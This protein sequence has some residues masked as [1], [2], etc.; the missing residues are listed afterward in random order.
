MP[1]QASDRQLLFAVLTVQL[2]L[3]PAEVVM[4]A[5]AAC[6]T[7]ASRGLGDRLVDQGA[8][9][10]QQR[11]LIAGM[12][13]EASR[14]NPAGATGA[15][16]AMSL[17]GDHGVART[18]AASLELSHDV[19]MPAADSMATEETTAPSPDSAR[20]THEQPERYRIG[21]EFGRGGQARVLLAMDRHLGREVAW[22]ELLPPAGHA[23]NHS[24]TATALTR[25]LREARITGLLEHPNIVPVHELGRRADGTLYYTMRVVRGQSL[26]QRLAT[27]PDLDARLELL[28]AFWDMCN[29]V[30]FAHSKGVIHRDLKPSNVMVGAF[31]ET[32]VLDWGLAKLQGV[33][34]TRGPEIATQVELLQGVR[35]SKTLAGWAVGTPSYMSPEQADGLIDHIDERSDVWGL[36]AVLY[37]LLTGHPP[38]EGNNPYHVVAQVRT[39]AVAPVASHCAHAP[40]ELVAVAERAL[41]RDPAQRY[42]S[43]RELAEDISAYMTG[44]RVQA[45]EY[46]SWEL[47]R[48]FAAR[49]KAAVAASTIV[50]AAVLVSLVGVAAAWRSAEDARAEEHTQRLQAH[51]VLAQAYGLEADRLLLD[52]QRLK[53]RIFAAASQLNNPANPAGPHHD[54]GFGL[55]RPDAD[56]LLVR[57]SSRLAQASH[58]QV[59]RLEARVPRRDALMD[60]TFSPDGRLVATAEFAQGFTVRE[61]TS[62]TDVMRVPERGTVTYALRFFPDGRRIA[63]GGKGPALQLWELGGN[64]PLLTIEHPELRSTTAVAVS[65]DGRMVASRGGQ[66]I[67]KIAVWDTETGELLALHHPGLQDVTGLAFSPDGRL[68]SCSY[69]DPV[70]IFDPIRGDGLVEIPV[71]DPAMVY[72]VDFSPDGERLLG[73]CTDGRTRI[74]DSHSGEEVEVLQ[75]DDDY[76]YHAA[77]SPD[78]A[79]VATAGAR[80]SVMLWDANTGRQ[81]TKLSDHSGG[82]SAVAF[83]PDG[84]H[85][86]SAGYDRALRLWALAPDDGLPR[87]H[88]PAVGYLV[89]H[90]RTGDRLL[91]SS[92]QD[93][94]QLWDTAS[95][96]QLWD[97]EYGFEYLRA[98]ALSPDGHRV[99]GAGSP[100]GVEIRDTRDGRLLQRLEGHDGSVWGLAWSP[101]SSTLASS[102]SDQTVRLWDLSAGREL[103]VLEE[104]DVHVTS[105]AF[106]R[107]GALLAAAGGTPEI[108]VWR[109]EDRA[110][111]HTLEGHDDWVHALGWVGDSHQLVSGS[112]DHQAILWDADAGQMLRRFT[113]HAQA[114]EM[115]DVHGPSRQL[116]TVDRDGTVLVWHLDLAE[117]SLWLL[118]RT[119][120]RDLAFAPD[121]RSLT[122]LEGRDAVSFP[123]AS[124]GGA[125]GPAAALAQAEADALLRLDGFELAAPE[126]D[127][128]VQAQPAP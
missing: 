86:A 17:D 77:F 126:P 26:D 42:Q 14:A 25:F 68:A 16:A 78:G 11:D 35:A 112:R 99:A 13:A 10:P 20:V 5:A 57:A 118:R 114:I 56:R 85:L 36:G 7:D 123:L 9:T 74:W 82:V 23:A 63:V 117:P 49:N 55:L 127:S 64:E 34:D 98:A 38:F 107:D 125:G 101:D 8:L 80:G 21:A 31:G 89:E 71:P 91:T 111:L 44:R 45:Y 92:L 70:R 113:G 43:A 93:G 109:V 27:C 58:R 75:S 81:L 50:V 48:R 106:S 66:D 76:F 18:F 105:V 19:H 53:A 103:A 2:G 52:Q 79:R 73:A 116:A 120:S 22:K 59:E 102:G 61:L 37:E 60:V 30:A 84:Q 100:A 110:L 40:P 94:M 39:E 108:W 83:S 119:G 95:G 32:V 46:S 65:P 29:A 51:F 15:L 47:I 121:G 88:L 72:W 3:A 24:A 28:G 87:L 62:G 104:P 96:T 41:Q 124:A 33:E 69:S 115:L 12:V 97:V 4:A 1:S 54:P 128:S 6:V 122:L 90:A 67:D